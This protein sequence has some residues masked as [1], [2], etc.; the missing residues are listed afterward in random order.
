RTVRGTVGAQTGQ[1]LGELVPSAVQTLNT[2]PNFCILRQARRV[3]CLKMQ[4]KQRKRSSAEEIE[5]TEKESHPPI[6]SRDATE[7]TETSARPGPST[8]WNLTS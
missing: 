5:T 4:K 2:F 6:K 1:T 3:S 7:E 8:V